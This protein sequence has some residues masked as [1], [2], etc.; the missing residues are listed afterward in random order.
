MDGDD[1]D[2][3]GHVDA[4]DDDQQPGQAAD[5]DNNDNNGQQNPLEYIPDHCRRNQNTW[6]RFPS[7]FI[8]PAKM[9]S[10][11]KYVQC[12]DE[13]FLQH[14]VH[15]VPSGPE[16]VL[17]GHDSPSLPSHMLAWIWAMTQIN[18][19]QS[20][21]GC[22]V[23]VHGVTQVSYQKKGKDLIA[24][25]IQRKLVIARSWE[26]DESQ[27]FE[28][29]FPDME[30]N[31]SMLTEVVSEFRSD[32]PHYAGIEPIQLLWG[33]IPVE[34]QRNG[35]TVRR[36]FHVLR[37]IPAPGFDLMRCL[38]D[39][40][41]RSDAKQ[42]FTVPYGAIMTAVSD[43]LN[44][45]CNRNLRIVGCFGRSHPLPNPVDVMDD[46]TSPM[47]AVTL[48]SPFL[49]VRKIMIQLPIVEVT[50]LVIDGF[51]R[52]DTRDERV[53]LQSFFREMQAAYRARIV[54]YFR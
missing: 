37:T 36:I 40:R 16:Y 12:V 49:V 32:A 13:S 33:I 46:P 44:Y 2:S 3:D 14:S 15:H 25:S 27:R 20:Y 23:P 39:I 45:E 54:V 30:R 38:V 1:N 29:T 17:V 6:L 4:G 53:A 21:C 41:Q 51:P 18:Q 48:L 5:H 50:G 8:R 19:M 52:S 47:S 10:V 31:D 28:A 7:E 42:K 26:V 9:C 35:I 22:V 11:N 43:V 24:T 34:Y